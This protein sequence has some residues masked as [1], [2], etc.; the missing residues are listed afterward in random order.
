MKN[1]Q[2]FSGLFLLFLALSSTSDGTKTTTS[3]ANSPQFM[4]DILTHIQAT[5]PAAWLSDLVVNDENIAVEIQH[6]S[7]TETYLSVDIFPEQVL[8]GVLEEA[9]REIPFDLGGFHFDF[10][11]DQIPEIQTFFTNHHQTGIAE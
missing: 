8:I 7:N 4:S 5:Y 6:P 3:M 9:N 1:L 11:T 10:A 2:L